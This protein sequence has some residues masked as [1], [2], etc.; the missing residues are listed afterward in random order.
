M[1]TN[2]L[3]QLVCLAAIH[4]HPEIQE[5]SSNPLSATKGMMPGFMI[6]ALSLDFLHIAMPRD[7]M[8]DPEAAFHISQKILQLNLKGNITNYGI[9]CTEFV[10]KMTYSDVHE[11]R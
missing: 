3:R 11:K 4:Q 7:L 6:Y 2:E 9:Y 10:V 8:K 5:P 1:S